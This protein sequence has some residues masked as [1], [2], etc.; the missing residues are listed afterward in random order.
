[1]PILRVQPFLL[2][3]RRNVPG[4]ENQ[5][6]K[7][8][9]TGFNVPRLATSMHLMKS[10]RRKDVNECGA[11]LEITMVMLYVIGLENIPPSGG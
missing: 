3:P 11:L 10:S 7:A 2:A 1:M 5:G 8:V 6:E 4:G 9:F